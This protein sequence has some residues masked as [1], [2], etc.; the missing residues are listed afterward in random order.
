MKLGDGVGRES[1]PEAWTY[2]YAGISYAQPNLVAQEVVIYGWTDNV[3]QTLD[4]YPY[5]STR[6]SSATSTNERRKFIGQFSDD[7][8]LSHFNARY[9][10]SGRGQFTSEEPIFL[11]IGD[12]TQVKQLSQKDQPTYLADPQALN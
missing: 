4:Y 7:S 12:A 8:G 5:G 11:S 6:I 1:S 10:D 3:V 2:T 9:Y